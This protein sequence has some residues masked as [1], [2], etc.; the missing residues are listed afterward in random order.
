MVSPDGVCQLLTPRLANSIC[1]GAD[2]GL[3]RLNDALAD[4]DDIYAVLKGWGLNTMVEPNRVH[5]PST[6][7]ST[8]S[9]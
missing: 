8:L 5:R 1:E 7:G 3:K 2:G 6:D 4:G 9:D